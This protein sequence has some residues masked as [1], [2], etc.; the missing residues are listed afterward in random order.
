MELKY[1]W[2]CIFYI[3]RTFRELSIKSGSSKFRIF[4]YLFICLFIYLFIYFNLCLLIKIE[5]YVFYSFH[6]VKAHNGKFHVLTA[7]DNVLYINVGGNQLN[8]SKY[9][10]LLNI[11]YKP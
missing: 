10:E 6:M 11:T 3:F 8:S 2:T 4:I 9:G 7:S 5:K 1:P